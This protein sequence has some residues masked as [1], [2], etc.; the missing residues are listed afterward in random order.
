M[1]TIE[2]EPEV[3]DNLT[4]TSTID[5][6]S[7]NQGKVLNEK[8]DALPVMD[9]YV[10]IEFEPPSSISAGTI[11]TRGWQGTYN[12]NFVPKSIII[13]YIGG[14]DVVHPLV[15]WYQN[16]VYCNLYRA[17][18]STITQAN[19]RTVVRVYY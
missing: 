2:R 17:S 15:F 11:G 1:G 5:A 7:A 6:L 19:A 9:R 16:A 12:F 13:T 10:D 8:I 4:S 3:I 14:S 18:G